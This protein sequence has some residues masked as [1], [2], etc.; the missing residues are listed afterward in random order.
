M[1]RFTQETIGVS[2]SDS[3]QGTSVQPARLNALDSVYLDSETTETPMH[4]GCLV[5]LDA[6]PLLTPTGRVRRT[7][8]TRHIVDRWSSVE[9]LHRRLAPKSNDAAPHFWE[10]TDNIGDCIQMIELLEGSDDRAVLDACAEIL[11]PVMPRDFPL[12]RLYVLSHISGNRVGFLFQMHHALC[13]GQGAAT[14]LISL[15]DEG[16]N[17]RPAVL[18]GPQFSGTSDS[19]LGGVARDTITQAADA[20]M[21][22]V[23][24]AKHSIELA[25]QG[26]DLVN[27]LTFLATNTRLRP[28]SSLNRPVSSARHL[29]MT[30]LDFPVVHDLAKTLGVT[31]NDVVLALVA[32]AIGKLLH[33]RGD[34]VS[35]LLLEALIPVSTRRPDQLL[36]PGNQTAVLQVPLPV[37]DQS[38][39]ERVHSIHRS[40]MARKKHHAAAAVSMVES[41]ASHVPFSLLQPISKLSIRHQNLVNLVVTNLRGPS[42]ELSFLKARVLRVVPFLPLA[43]SLPISVAIAS[44]AT[45]LEIGVQSDP[46]V[47]PDAPNFV[48]HLSEQLT[49]LRYSTDQS[50]TAPA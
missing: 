45:K 23:D 30:Q 18:L 28:Q 44:Y 11:Q 6:R 42:E 15:M 25:S 46:T 43:T 2:T 12:W 1:Q 14:A 20:L 4:V 41:L 13:D 31:I 3:R 22:G 37:G 5:F 17:N 21:H 9:A 32:G 39:I 47:C 35:G 29:N 19:G 26:L 33:D 50:V 16:P 8:I 40:T 38:P 48:G 24:L 36:E 49:L 7:A 10:R 27:G 34:N